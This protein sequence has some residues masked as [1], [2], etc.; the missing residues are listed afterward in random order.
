MEELETRSKVPVRFSYRA[1]GST[2]GLTELKND[3]NA[4]APLMDF[5]GSEIPLPNE[6]WQAFQEK[7]VTVMHLPVLFFAVSFFQ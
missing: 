6:D 5:T 7:N 2:V 4:T 1:T 3:F